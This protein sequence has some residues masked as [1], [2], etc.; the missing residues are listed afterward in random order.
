[1]TVAIPQ[2][3]TICKSCG[4]LLYGREPDRCCISAKRLVMN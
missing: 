4:A 1:M 3:W 2:D